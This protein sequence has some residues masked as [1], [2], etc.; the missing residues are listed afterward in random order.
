MR[1]AVRLPILGVGLA[2]AMFAPLA[3]SAAPSGVATF[4][5]TKNMHPLGEAPAPLAGTGVFNSDIAFWGRYAVQGTYNGWNVVDISEPDNPTTILDY[6]ECVSDVN[7]LANTGG[8]QGDLVLWATDE[9]ADAPDILVRAHNSNTPSNNETS[10]RFCGGMLLPGS[11]EGIS[12]HDISDLENPQIMSIVD[13]PQGTH[14]LTLVPDTDNGRILIYSSASSGNNPGLDI[15]QIPLDDL[16]AAEFLRFERS[17]FDTTDDRS[18]H[19]TGVILGDVM[20]VACAGGNGFTVW[21]IDPADGATL[22]D[23]VVMYSKVWNDYDEA[24]DRFDGTVSIGH[25]AAF[26]FDGSILIFGHEPGGGG[27]AQCQETTNIVN[28]SM[29]FIDTESGELLGWHTLPRP[30]G[31]TENCTIHNFNVVPLPRQGKQPLRNV[32]VHGSYQSGIGVVDFS[33]PANAY[34][35]AYADPAPLSLEGLVVGGDWSTHWYNGRIYESDITRG[36]FVWNLSDSRVAGALKLGHL[37]PQTQ[38]FSI[39]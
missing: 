5:W 18:C 8:N 14:T 27:Q 12:V 24:D 21:S 28:K 9:N 37:N 25:S 32:L 30:Q 35:F 1:V 39:H 16:S 4:E 15:I 11:F 2:V 13:L 31:P 3:A 33:D 29:W 26:S 6:D 34:E 17:G 19:D 22:E 10:P 38:E 36:V 23:P 7:G 20:R